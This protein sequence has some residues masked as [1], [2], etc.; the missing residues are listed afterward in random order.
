[1][2]QSKRKIVLAGGY[3]IWSA[4]DD[5][6]MHFLTSRLRERFGEDCE[7]VVIARHPNPTFD[8][9]YGVRTIRGF[10]YDS[11]ALSSGKWMRGLNFTDDRSELKALADEIASA[12]LLV[13]GAGNFIT[14]LAL[15]VLRGH[16]AQFAVLTLIADMAQTPVMLFGLS[17]NR[18]RHPWSQRA[19]RWMLHRASAVTF[20]E[21]RAIENLEA[22]NV[23]LPAFELLPDAALGSP[24]APADRSKKI[25]QAEGI[26][27]AGKA[28]LAVSLRDLSWMGDHQ[29]YLGRI[30]AV[31]NLWLAHPNRGVL[32]VPQ[33][34]YNVEDPRTDDRYV[35]KQIRPLLC[36]LDRCAFVVGQYEAPD[37]ECLYRE[38]RVTLATRLHGC[39]FS[40]K[41]GTPVIGLSYE[42]KVTG[43][44]RQLGQPL[45]ALPLET[46]PDRVARELEDLVQQSAKLHP[47]LKAKV[48]DLCDR[49]ERYVDIACELIENSTAAQPPRQR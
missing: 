14:E 32:F 33:C 41:M 37:I 42:D 11:K 27:L 43:F 23:Q 28:V 29:A 17:A 35:A 24:S 31:I 15:D 22:S 9:Y 3:T 1:M 20:R 36:S 30:A 10:E 26:T 38:A 46:P 45:W 16:F 8:A 13:L 25:L 12:D 7:F 2:H 5:A 44:F 47:Q 4:G 40:A 18:L 19:A 49:L 39:V 34:S 6:P 48:S 21:P